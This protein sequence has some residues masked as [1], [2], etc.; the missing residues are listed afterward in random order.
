MATEERSGLFVRIPVAEAEKLDRAAFELK[1]PKQDLIAGLVARYVDPSSPER[2]A[3]LGE[4]AGSR[5]ITVEAMD[6]SL[7]I[8]RA[9]FQPAAEPLEVLTLRQAA[10]LLQADVETVEEMAEAEELPG[11]RVGEQWRFSRQA[12]L[13]W[14]A[15]DRED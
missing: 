4:Y 2:L 1:A 8:G 6:D 11:R 12:V 15:A 5:R 3:E 10:D 7:S 14:L 13:K 9:A